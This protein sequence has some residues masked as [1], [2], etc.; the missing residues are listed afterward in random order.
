MAI[1]IDGGPG[2]LD[3]PMLTELRS[4]GVYLF[5]G[6]LNTMQI[7]QEIDQ[8]YGEF[9]SLLRRFIQ[10]LLNEMFAKYH[11]QMYEQQSRGI[12]APSAPSTLNR[13]HYGLLLS[14]CPADEGVS[15]MPPI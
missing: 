13:S 11:E 15:E 1:K 14:G 10:Q 5:P 7:T 4:L 8:N 6:V 2:R 9:T 3:I 12:N